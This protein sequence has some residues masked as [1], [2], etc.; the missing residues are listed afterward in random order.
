MGGALST[1]VVVTGLGIVGSF[2]GG[3]EPLWNALERGEPRVTAVE[4]LP[5]FHR[6]HARPRAAL[7]DDALLR[8]WVSARVARRMSRPSLLAV[9]AAR[10][11]TRDA[12]LAD[13]PDACTGVFL[14]TAFGAI[15][16]TEGMLRALFEQ[17]PLS[18]S[19]FHFTECVANAP[20]AQVAIQCRAR[21]PNLT[22]TQREA[23]P[24]IALAHAARAVRSGR[25]QRAYTGGV[26]EMAPI[27]HA[28]LDRFS[29]LTRSEAPAPFGLGRDGVLASE[30]ATVLVLESDETA[31]AR[32]APEAARVVGAGSG[33]DPTAPASAWGHGERQ[34]ADQV[35]RGLSRSGIELASIDRIVSGASGSVGGDRLEA[36]LLVELWDGRALP[37][38][39]TPKGVVGEYA[40]AFLGAAVLAVHGGACSP[41]SGFSEEDPALG[42][43]PAAGGAAAPG[44]VLVTSVAAGGAMA[45]IVL[46]PPRDPHLRT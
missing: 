8:E 22:I 39:W 18:V 1:D 27:L 40:G 28:I 5:G 38:I 6:R 2:G 32:G 15:S 31:R 4:R 11:A 46:D 24:L 35:R 36:R 45:W 9:A 12:Q 17:G 26:D 33:F 20:S 29:A 23:G 7:V 37:P 41:P 3:S 30:G 13:A 21:G 34:L 25:A 19:P 43:A 42:V 14:A 10:M 44:R 16:P